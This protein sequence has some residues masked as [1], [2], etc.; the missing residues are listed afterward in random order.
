MSNVSY[1]NNMFCLPAYGM[2]K[3]LTALLNVSCAWVTV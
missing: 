1:T 2:K 3:V